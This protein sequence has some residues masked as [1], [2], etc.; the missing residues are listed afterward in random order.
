MSN[1]TSAS[2]SIYAFYI[3]GKSLY[4]NA[5][6]N[7]IS[8]VS[9]S[10]A[11]T[12]Y[13]LNIGGGTMVNVNNNSINSLSATG[14]TTMYAIYGYTRGTM[15]ITNNNIANVST[16]GDPTVS[17]TF[18]GIFTDGSG[19][20]FTI[21]G[22]NIG[23]A[24]SNSIAIGTNGATTGITHLYGI[25][26]NATG[27][28]SI[29]GNTIQN[30]S[31]FGTTASI[32]TAIVNIY[33]AITLNIN[34]N[35]LTN[36]TLAG[37]GEYDGILNSGAVTTSINMNNNTINSGILSAAI[38]SGPVNLIK[39]NS[40]GTSSTLSINSNT[41]GG[42]TFT[43][44]T[45]GTGVLT[46]IW[47]NGTPLNSTINNNNFNN[48][49]LKTT[50]NIC[51]IANTNATPAN[52]TKTVQGN[53]ITTGCARTAGGLGQFYCYSDQSNSPGSV[54][55]DIS[56]NNFSNININSLN[57]GTFYGIY[58]LDG[59]A[60]PNIAVYNNTISNVTCGSSNMSC[61]YLN[62]I[63]GTSSSPDL[64]YGNTVSNLSAAAT[65]AYGIFIGNSSQYV[66][67]YNNTLNNYTGG[68]TGSSSTLYG[69]YLGG[70]T[71][72]N[73]YSNNVNSL[74]LSAGNNNAI[75][76]VYTSGGT[77]NSIFKNKIFALNCSGTNASAYGCN[78]NGGATNNIYNNFIS[79]IKAPTSANNNAVAGIYLGAGTANNLFYNTIYLNASSTGSTF[80]SSGIY[81]VTTSTLTLNNNLIIN[82]STP[83]SAS[84]YTSALR[85]FN[86]TL[87]NYTS[88]SNNNNFYAGT[89]SARNVVFY[90]GTTAYQ[91]IA[92]FKS[93]VTPRESVS[94]TENT[95]FVNTAT[96]PYDLHISGSNTSLCESAGVR[97]TTPLAITD[98]IDGDIRFGETGYTG[99]G[100]ATDIG[101]DEFSGCIPVTVTS[102]PSSPSAVCSGS[103]VLNL[104]V[105]VSGTSNYN[106][107][108]QV[109]NGGWVNLTNGGVYGSTAITTG[110]VSNTNTLT[111]TN[112]DYTYNGKQY[113]CVVK[114]CSGGTSVASDGNATI[115]LI[116]L[117]TVSITGSSTIYVGTTTTLSPTT[118]GNWVSNNTGIATVTTPAG[119]VSGITAGSATFTFTQTSSGCS[120]TTTAVTINAVTWNG[121]TSS[122][123]NTASNWNGGIPTAT[124]DVVIAPGTTYTPHI[125]TVAGNTPSCKNLN[126]VS[127]AILTIDA[128]GAL[129]VNGTTTLNAAQCLVLKADSIHGTASFID[130]GFAGTGTAR[131][132]KYLYTGRWW[133]IGSPVVAITGSGAYGPLSTTPST[134]TRDLYWN[135][136]TH[137]Y[138]TVVSSDNLVPMK[139]Y[140]FQNYN[141][142]AVVATY[143]G[144][145]NTGNM[146]VNLTRTSGTK[147][148][149]NLISNPYPSAI[150]VGSQKA[151]QAGLTTTNI[152]S[153]IQYKVPGTFATWNSM[154]SGTGVNGGGQTIPAMQGFWVRVKSGYTTG[155]IKLTN[156]MRVQSSQSAY[157]LT[158]LSNLFRIQVARD[159]MVDESVVTFYTDALAGYD[160]Y[161]SQK[162]LSDE[163]SYPQLYSV[164]SDNV[165]V[166]INGQPVLVS[167]SERIVPLGFVTYVA[168]TFKITASNLTQFDAN[169]TVYLEDVTLHTTQN[170]S[171]NKTYTFT[172]ATGTFNSR[173]KLHFIY[174]T[175]N[176]LPI[177]LMSFDAKCTNSS[178]DIHWTT[179]TETNNDYFTIERS[180]DATNWELVSKVTGAG[181]SNSVLNYSAKDNAPVSG[182]S[183]YRLKQTD[184][185]G[186]TETFGAVAVNC[187]GETQQMSI[188][189]YPN[190][191]TSEVTAELKNITSETA[192][193]DVYDVFGRKVFA[194]T[195]SQDELN[196]KAFSLNLADLAS[197][198]YF[199][200]FKSD[201]YSGTTK[202]IKK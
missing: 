193:I 127:G 72:I 120:N 52:A 129:T 187:S 198:I 199:V 54:S 200:D 150:S 41:L 68:G 63:G 66:N 60:N 95:V 21:S 184:Y 67:V 28:I 114:N 118:G 17:Y 105:Q 108:W 6:N 57:T 62:G 45:G 117:P 197:G 51:L 20:N 131:I 8:N 98:D 132:E 130:N 180:T 185:N 35:I 173:F 97:I 167:G 53:Y 188:S 73:A 85:F 9:T 13:G 162:M 38:A 183:Y 15:N 112:A 44:S 4:V 126:I 26:N 5:Y 186:Q 22:N 142:T 93:L 81:S 166:A 107:Q 119:V 134:G 92:N 39:C 133:Y 196:L 37:T 48:L 181:N 16:N 50:G 146:T 64:V 96:T 40:A 161:D 14:T 195:I 189:I 135:E 42:I 69:I 177:Q 59:A 30:C 80:G 153:T 11:A 87:T 158:D 83:G 159:T 55:I 144:T 102:Q 1:I 94:L 157:K 71:L 156:A 77:T 140:A 99:N 111:I 74:T 125:T 155:S 25:E 47:V 122:D 148:G 172:S 103:N 123:W 176:P 104:T 89:P 32:F 121:I 179:A 79:D 152:E 141:K 110:S 178:V 168:G 12:M 201:S 165:Q 149:F 160:D 101:A 182:V 116:A 49:S 139:G 3:G 84:G 100:T 106:Y 154:G 43:G 23:D 76:G 190:P 2:T 82:L 56:G 90:N 202:I 61:I 145:P 70:G 18:N 19:G 191:F 75:Y 151:P 138:V 192:T 175:S 115:T 128:G 113:R 109:N 78:V 88:A 58:N 46:C 10:G 86:T 147:E 36:N 170:L 164:T 194:K 7:T 169:T 137:A 143:T 33:G 171:S 163:I 24:T 174:L 34:N 124:S 27:N 29:T 31:S 91:T 136:P 65:L